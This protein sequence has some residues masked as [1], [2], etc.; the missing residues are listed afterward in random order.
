MLEDYYVKPSTVDRVRASWLAPQIAF[1]G[2]ESNHEKCSFSGD[3]HAGELSKL[4]S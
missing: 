1:S 4:A 3:R 2:T